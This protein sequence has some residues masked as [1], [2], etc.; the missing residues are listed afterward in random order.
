MFSAT[1]PPEIRKLASMFLKKDALRVTIGKDDLVACSRVSQTVEVV[2]PREKPRKLESLL[3][4]YHASQNYKNR[5]LIFVLYKKEATE[6]ENT[7]RRKGWKCVAI[8]GDKS[9]DSRTQALARFKSGSEPLLIATDVAARGLDVPDVS[10]VINYT[11]PLTI[12]DYIHRIG[13]TGRA[14][15]SG[16]S[17]TLF[18]SHDKAKSGELV[19]V[20]REAKQPI[21]DALT[22]F[23]M[24]TKKKE[25]QMYGAH[26][27]EVDPSKKAKKVTFDSDEEN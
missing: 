1:W 2:E 14:G 15:K 10:Y 12:E 22:A 11:F 6:V 16:I 4:K 7:L 25:H 3:T 20:L 26:F 24:F 21:P 13:R 8:H 27:K 5:I 19:H 23:G 9:Q 17:H 18:T